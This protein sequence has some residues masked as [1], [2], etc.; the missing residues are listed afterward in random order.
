MSRT[1]ETERRIPDP[2]LDRELAAMAVSWN[3]G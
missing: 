3:Q 1:N 2:D